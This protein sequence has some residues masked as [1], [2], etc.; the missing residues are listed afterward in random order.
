MARRMVSTVIF[1]PQ[2]SNSD[3]SQFKIDKT[4]ECIGAG[5]DTDY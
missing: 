5:K 3:K 1:N 4:S 2:R